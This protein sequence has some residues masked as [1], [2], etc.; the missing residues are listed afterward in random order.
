MQARHLNGILITAFTGQVSWIA[1]PLP[2]LSVG[3][4][5]LHFC[6]QRPKL[7]SIIRNVN[8]PTPYIHYNL[9]DKRVIVKEVTGSKVFW[10]QYNIHTLD[11]LHPGSAYYVLVNAPGGVTFR[12]NSAKSEF[13]KRW[14]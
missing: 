3:A 8:H 4:D 14:F 5:F 12:P 13:R 1:K 9:G 2:F 10:P 7:M 6:N 11:V